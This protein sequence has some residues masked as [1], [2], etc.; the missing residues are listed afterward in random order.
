M[1]IEQLALESKLNGD[2]TD[3]T[4]GLDPNA[5]ATWDSNK[6]FTCKCDEGYGGHD[7]AD[8]LC[9]RGDDPVTSGQVDEIQVLECTATG[10]SFQLSFRSAQTSLIPFDAAEV[11]IEA[12]LESLV[13]IDDVQVEYTSGTVACSD[14]STPHYILVTFLTN[15]ADLPSLLP[16][17]DAL[18]GGINVAT[19]GQVLG[20]ANSVTGTKEDAMCSNKGNC[21]YFSGECVCAQGFGSSDSR[22]NIGNKG[23]CG[24]R[25][26]YANIE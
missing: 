5:A 14:Q 22:G 9:P 13:T 4:Y 18:T 20:T 6:I 7:C 16:N 26:P 12:A 15:H 8:I 24:F 17:V 2:S 19:D 3:Y 1:T 23:D 11:D 25:L 21:N 10:G